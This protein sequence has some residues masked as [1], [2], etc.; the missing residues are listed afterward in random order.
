MTLKLKIVERSNPQMPMAPKKYYASPAQRDEVNLR[1]LAEAISDGS[2]LRT[3]DIMAVLEGLL[4]ELPKQLVEGRIVKLGDFGS[5]TLNIS[6]VGH[7][8][9]DEVSSRSVIGKRIIFRPGK[10]VRKRL[11]NLEQKM[12]Q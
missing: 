1:K 7:D 3:T 11:E 12:I 6:S 2:T 4:L 10:E 5:F 9:A 8:N